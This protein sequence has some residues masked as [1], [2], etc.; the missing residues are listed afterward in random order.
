MDDGLLT[1]R[2]NGKLKNMR[3]DRQLQIF[4]LTLLGIPGV[5]NTTVRN[6]L[7][8]NKPR[9]E[10]ADLLDESFARSLNIGKINNGLQK[11]GVKWN[12]LEA[13][14]D[15]TLERANSCGAIVLQPYSTCYPQRL[16]INEKYPPIIFARG[17]IRAL[18]SE[19]AVSIIGTRDPTPFGATMGRKLAQ[20][21][22]ENG[23]V[24]VSGLALGCDSVAHEG[25]LN[26]DGK[27]VAVLPTP[28][29]A[30]VYPKQNKELAQRILDKGGVLLSEYAPGIE[31]HDKQLVSN[32]IARDEWQPGL[33]DGVIAIET[34]STGGTNHALNHAIKT[35][36]PIAVFDYSSREAMRFYEDERFSGNVER[37]Q[38]GASGIFEPESI[39]RFKLEMEKYRQRINGN[40]DNPTGGYGQL[41]LS[42]A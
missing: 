9:I 20:I 1:F 6:T 14:A 22:A 39:E 15:E 31:L 41:P 32:L 19:K 5:A 7:R 13:Q 35:N 18:N 28:I 30:P 24:I 2:E 34:S 3:D 38:Q 27:T 26:V 12:Y 10:A 4:I 23:Y 8:S 17:D 21:L 29:D 33:S 40:M 37:L 11:P 16:L 25:A 36:T 42:F